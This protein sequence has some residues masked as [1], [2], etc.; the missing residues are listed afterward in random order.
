MPDLSLP[1]GVDD[2]ESQPEIPAEEPVVTTRSGRQ[3]RPPV[4]YPRRFNKASRKPQRGFKENSYL[5]GKD[6]NQKLKAGTLNDQFLMALE[7]TETVQF[8]KSADLAA[9]MSLLETNTDSEENT[10]NGCIQCR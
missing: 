8:L 5:Y 9:M 4:R 7:W 3:V 2:D 6:R 10:V 1:E